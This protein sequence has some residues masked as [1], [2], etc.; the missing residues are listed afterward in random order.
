MRPNVKNVSKPSEIFLLFLHHRGY[1]FTAHTP[2]ARDIPPDPVPSSFYKGLRLWCRSPSSLHLVAPKALTPAVQQCHGCLAFLCRSA[3]LS[4]L[5][6][7]LARTRR[8]R[9]K[10]S[11]LQLQSTCPVRCF[12]SQRRNPVCGQI[13]KRRAMATIDTRI[14]LP[15]C[16]AAPA[17][18]YI[19]FL[20]VG[21]PLTSPIYRASPLLAPSP[22]QV[23]HPRT[24]FIWLF[25]SPTPSVPVATLPPSFGSFPTSLCFVT[26]A[27]F[28]HLGFMVDRSQAVLRA[29]LQS[30]V[31]TSPLR[32]NLSSQSSNTGLV[33]YVFIVITPIPLLTSLQLGFMAPNGQTNLA[34]KD[35]I[36]ALT[37]LKAGVPMIGGSQSK[38]TIAGQS[39]GATMVRTLLAIPSASSLFKSAILQSDP[40]VMFS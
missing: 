22:A 1:S 37:V 15:G 11:G 19:L 6:S 20:P 13:R 7:H 36:N 35:I 8:T 39:S 40:M 29:I 4:P 38:I 21:S 25:M 18:T 26:S 12:C 3:P 14:N 2:Q 28:F 31:L 5:G 32:P 27:H 24:A 23:L 34:V 16:E 33:V 10:G 9:S 30:T 17:G